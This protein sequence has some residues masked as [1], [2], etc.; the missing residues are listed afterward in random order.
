MRRLHV[1]PDAIVERGMDSCMQSVTLPSVHWSTTQRSSTAVRR[2]DKQF[3]LLDPG[4]L[5]YLG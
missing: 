5:D 1:V 4:L 3:T 2:T